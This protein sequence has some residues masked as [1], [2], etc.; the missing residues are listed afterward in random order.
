MKIKY[1]QIEATTV[2]VTEPFVVSCKDKALV[3]KSLMGTYEMYSEELSTTS[4]EDS[5]Y[6]RLLRIIEQCGRLMVEIEKPN[7]S[8]IE[9]Y[10]RLC[11]RHREVAR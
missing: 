2:E 10:L 3:I 9:A 11:A 4:L 1:K 5:S 7:S 8:G 6:P